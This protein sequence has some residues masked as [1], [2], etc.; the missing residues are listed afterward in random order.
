[1]FGG[2]DETVTTTFV[3]KDGMTPVVRGIRN[4]MEQFKRDAATGFGL[5]GGISIFNTATRAIGAVTDAVGDSL[6]AFREDALSQA[7]LRSALEANIE[8]W[9]G[10]ADAIERVIAARMDLGFSDDEQRASL[11]LLVAQVEDVNDA[12][13]I[14]R[15]AM[16]LARLKGIG[17]AEASTILARAYLGSTTQLSKMGIKLA[18]GVD[19]M[20]AIAA[21]QQR[22]AGQAEAWGESSA[23]AAEVF[24]IKVGELQESIGALV[25]GP[26]DLFVTFLGNIVDRLTG[27]QGAPT[28]LDELADSIYHVDAAAEQAAGHGLERVV[29]TLDEAQKK[30][31]NLVVAARASGSPLSAE[32]IAKL[33][34]QYFQLAEAL[35]VSTDGFLKLAT[36]VEQAGGGIEQFRSATFALVNGT[37]STTTYMIDAWQMTGQTV[38]EEADGATRTVR[39]MARVM[40]QE[41]THAVVDMRSAIKEGKAG[42]IEQFRDLAWQS[43][44]PFAEKNYSEWLHEQERKALRR[45]RQANRAG[46]PGIAAQ[47]RQLAADIRG[48]YQGL[49]GYMASIAGQTVGALSIIPGFGAL[50]DVLG[51]AGVGAGGAKKHKRKHKGHRAMGGPVEAGG[52]YLVGEN[53]PEL[54]QMGSQRGNVTANHRMGGG[55][56]NV[57]VDG[58]KLFTILDGRNGRA[59]AMGG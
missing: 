52:T 20:E 29:L 8:G 17:L 14:Q 42:I 7:K 49:P 47:H 57:Y 2:R 58:Q 40:P 15:T 21:V 39:H 31:D 35:G 18:K 5:A 38:Q 6:T 23:G 59:I 30:V 22:A 19:G 43:K 11:A 10:N 46:M 4:T 51:I 45:M 53:G 24:D 28:L 48:E 25:S 41:V 1:M 33:G 54:L 44:H 9:D 36:R 56:T 13:A 37:K 3:A 12:L 32:W 26:A 16:D 34:P 27:N 55:V 50:D